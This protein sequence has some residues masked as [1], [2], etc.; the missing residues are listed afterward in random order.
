MNPQIPNTCVTAIREYANHEFGGNIS[1]GAL[2][3]YYAQSFGKYV[4]LTGVDI[5][6]I[7]PFVK[8]FFKI[9][10]WDSYKAAIDAGNPVMTGMLVGSSGGETTL[11]NVLIIGYNRDNG[12][13]VY[14]D[15]QLGRA[16]EGR[17]GS[18]GYY[19]VQLTGNK[20]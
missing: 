20:R 18:F 9:T 11:H 17:P 5:Q 7:K 12:N 6:D 10:K 8:Y 13:Y 4:A 19:M 14:M 15:P 2:H 3:K 1:E 16:L